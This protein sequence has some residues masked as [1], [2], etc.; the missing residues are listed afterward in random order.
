[1][2]K[3]DTI[4]MHVEVKTTSFVCHRRHKDGQNSDLHDAWLSNT[5]EAS[6]DSATS[7]GEIPG[8][9]RDIVARHE[10]SDDDGRAKNV[11]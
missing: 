10:T 3:F 7:T 8:V 9:G 6:L 5:C 4:E 2:R 1:M 11:L